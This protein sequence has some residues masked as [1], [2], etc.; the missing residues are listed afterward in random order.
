MARNE[1][2][3]PQWTAFDGFSGDT[4]YVGSFKQSS[5]SAQRHIDHSLPMTHAVH[6]MVGSDHGL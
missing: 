2:K 6:M 5:R 3:I 4:G 1:T